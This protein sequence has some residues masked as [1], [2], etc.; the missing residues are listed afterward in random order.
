MGAISG[1]ALFFVMP[2]FM[3]MGTVQDAVQAQYYEAMST[4]AADGLPAFVRKLDQIAAA[5]PAAPFTP[6]IQEMIQVVGLLHPGSVPDRAA[7]MQAMKTQASANPAITKILRRVETLD[8]YYAAAAKGKPESA[9]ATLSEAVFEDSPF[10]TLALADAALRMHD[11]SKAE[12]LSLQLIE[13]NPYSPLL[14]NAYVILGFC[15]TYRGNAAGAARQFQRALAVTPLPTVYGSTRDLLRSTYRFIR[16]IP[17]SIGN[18]FEEANPT[19]IAGAQEVKD[20]RSLSFRNGAFFLVDKEQV[21]TL[22]LDGKVT[23]TKAGRKLVDMAIAADGKPYYLAED[24]IDL[25]T[26]TPTQLTITVAGKSKVLKKLRSLAV[27]SQ[28]DV[29]ILDVDQGLF[30]GSPA[31]GALAL[32]SIA[33]TRGRLLRIDS[34]G[35]LFILG[36]DQRSILV[37]SRDGKQLATVAPD[38]A[39]GKQPEIE[40]F[41]L[42]SLNHIYILDSTSIQIFAMNEGGAGLDKTNAGAITLDPRPQFKNLKALAVS[43][44][45]EMVTTGKNEDN[46]VIFQ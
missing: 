3:Q 23:D 11:Y 45:G 28:G 16:P 5:S 24:S 7:R 18:I 19:R 42:D 30:K 2:F 44:T 25:G 12:T 22:S 33:A 43:A 34:R 36:E 39:N 27:D 37:L 1:L 20:P 29:Y 13:S 9:V 21:V 8:Q 4:A 35:N 31:G 17:G 26:G 40:Y 46:W 6:R 15:D 32:K 38:S 10:G 14:A 41:A